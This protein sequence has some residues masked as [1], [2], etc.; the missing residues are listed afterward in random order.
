VSTLILVLPKLYF[1]GH[2][3]MLWYVIT[4]YVTTLNIY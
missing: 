3:G 2:G 4:P 1:M